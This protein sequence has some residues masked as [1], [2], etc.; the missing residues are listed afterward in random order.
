MPK[1]PSAIRIQRPNSPVLQEDPPILLPRILFGSALFCLCIMFVAVMAVLKNWPSRE[2]LEAE[3]NS[4]EVRAG[5]EAGAGDTGAGGPVAVTPAALEGSARRSSVN[6]TAV[7]QS[8]LRCDRTSFRYCA[9]GPSSTAERHYYDPWTSSCVSTRH[10]MPEVV[11]NRG[12]NRFTSFEQCRQTCV[13]KQPPSRQCSSGTHFVACSERDMKHNWWFWDGDG[14]VKWNFPEGRCPRTAGRELT[15]ESACRQACMPSGNHT[16]QPVDPTTFWPSNS[17]LC[18]P[19][20]MRFPFFA[21]R[22]G[23]GYECI[24]LSAQ[25]LGQKVCL[26]G[27]TANK[28]NTAAAC[29]AACRGSAKENRL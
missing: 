25:T 17:V 16:D 22:K 9:G 7:T 5:D 4:P 6:S 24:R 3:G 21:H 15:T 26:G 12:R 28:F 19:S 23:N 18:A 14:C 10:K 29:N 2:E 8:S 27:S 1:A 11:C 13:T 20:V